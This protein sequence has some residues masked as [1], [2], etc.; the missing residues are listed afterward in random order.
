MCRRRLT[1]TRWHINFREF[2]GGADGGHP[3][4]K[5]FEFVVLKTEGVKRRVVVAG[6]LSWSRL[7]VGP[8]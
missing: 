7:E 4:A 2:S 8:P 1:H 3:K 6:H 5:L